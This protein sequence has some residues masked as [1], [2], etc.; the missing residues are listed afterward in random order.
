[1]PSSK[2]WCVVRLVA[3]G[4][5]AAT[6]ATSVSAMHAASAGSLD[7]RT[8]SQTALDLHQGATDLVPDTGLAPV[9][10]DGSTVGGGVVSV[11]SMSVMRVSRCS[12]ATEETASVAAR[13]SVSAAAATSA[14]AGAGRGA[15]DGVGS[16]ASEHFE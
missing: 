9:V 16:T 5:E 13:G 15:V 8:A 2:S 7:T 12:T 4:S 1:M 10:G 3:S 14:V 11:V 6:R